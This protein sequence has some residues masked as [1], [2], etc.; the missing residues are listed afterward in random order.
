MKKYIFPI[1][2]LIVFASCSNLDL[3][4]LAYGSSETW[5]ST[6]SEIDMSLNGLYKDAFIGNDNDEW[7]DD[8]MYRNSLTEFTSA[9]VNGLSGN[10]TTLW[11]NSYKA[12]TRAN[13]VLAGIDR[14]S[15]ITPTTSKKYKGEARFIRAYEYSRLIAHFGDVPYYE[16]VLKLED[17]FSMGKTS[18]A[19]IL[20]SIYNDF[21]SAAAYLPKVYSTKEN[22][23]ATQGA[24]YAMK[25]RIALY[26]GD[27]AT[28]SVAAKA[29]MD[30]AATAGYDLHTDYSNLFLSSTKN[31]KE[32]IFAIPRSVVLKVTLGGIQDYIPRLAGG[33]GAKHPSWD[34]LCSYLC[35][36]GLPIDESPLF[37][38][39][40]PF[41]NRDPRC[42]ASI[43]EF[44]S[45]HLG[46][47]YNPHPDSLKVLNLSTNKY[48][49]NNDNRA[50]AQY[51]SFNGLLLKKGIDGDCLLNSWQIEPDKIIIRYADVLLIYAEAKIELN[52]IDQ[53]VRDAMNKVRAR[54][55]KVAY[56]NTAAYPAITATTQVGLRKI[57]RAERHMEFSFEGLRYMDLIRWKIADKVLNNP[58]YG[59][60][61][62]A[63]LRTKVVKTGLWFFPQTPA[64]DDNGI[65]DF[66]P[67][68][69][70][71]LIKLITVRAFDATKQYSW[72]IPTKEVQI[73]S[74]LTQ[75][76]NY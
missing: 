29:C 23:R 28:A 49:T 66:K 35:T 34:L 52:E 39:R 73:N 21:D 8:F 38:P 62:P 58:N 45:P 4:P 61:D 1:I 6:A 55:Y 76:P 32:T 17:A 67:M 69:D 20:K 33:W 46:Y 19:E 40:N 9:T 48:V 51:A 25:A 31:S 63:D 10:V 11:N 64:I 22:K 70:A 18:K 24:A 75:N 53:S 12:I 43:V 15:S 7:T 16:N 68:A 60:L 44:Q 65:A 41:K 37:N 30:I 26:M 27:Y 54:A 3:N 14:A 72:P 42:T 13:T 59:M 5:Y 2:G 57:L 47:I 50:N 36:D 56:T 74:N 71:G